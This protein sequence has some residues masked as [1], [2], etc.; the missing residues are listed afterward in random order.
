MPLPVVV[1]T[2]VVG[3]TPA[4]FRVVTGGLLVIAG[5]GDGLAYPAAQSLVTAIKESSAPPGL[6]EPDSAATDMAAPQA[7]VVS[8]G[9]ALARRERPLGIALATGAT[10]ALMPALSRWISR[11]V[12]G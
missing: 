8:P 7:N 6:A 3:R 4:R 2:K 5:H 11:R 1:E 9:R 12:R 10:V